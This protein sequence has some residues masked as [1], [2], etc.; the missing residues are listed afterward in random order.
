MLSE[1]IGDLIQRAVKD[2]QAKEVLPPFDMSQIEIDYP[3]DRKNGDYS[4][5][6]VLKIS[7]LVKIN[8]LEVSKTLA[9]KILAYPEA[10]D[11]FSKVT[12]MAPGFVNFFIKPEYLH[13]RVK[14]I[15]K[16]KEGFGK[17]DIGN[18]EKVNVEFISANPT[19]PL[20]LGNGRGGFCGDVLASVLESCGY[21]VTR[22]YY[23]NDRGEQIVKLGHS[24]LKDA[25]AVYKGEY[26]DKLNKRI[27]KGELPE[28]VGDEAAG[29]ILKEM[30]KPAV[31]RMG[32]NFDVWF[33]EKTLYDKGGVDG[34]IRVLEE[35]GHTYK[36]EGATWFKSQE[37]EDDKD[38]V[39]VRENGIRT[40]FAS[41]I[42]YLENKF[43]R[44]FKKLILFVGA[45]HYGYIARLKAGCQAMGFDKEAIDVILEQLVRLFKDGQEVRMSKRTGTYVT[46]DELLDEVG[47]DVARFFFLQRSANT[48]LN[49]D[50]NLAK[51]QSQKNPVFYIQYAH[52]RI[53][54]ILRKKKPGLFSS[55]NSKLLVEEAELDLIKDLIKFPEVILKTAKDYQ[56][57][58]LAQYSIDIADAFH[59]FYEKC[60]V[61]GEKPRLTQARLSL[62]LATKIV[63]KN[64]LN[65]MGISAPEK[66]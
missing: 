29:I 32:I 28:E 46:L 64:T 39:L 66:M 7:K 61:I 57:Q 2:L 44:G 48:H 62:T 3:T 25:D 43:Q 60:Q 9:D 34:V 56:V 38:R 19:G 49:F 31:K 14:E 47:L 50:L 20:T 55:T 41:D 63:L 51:E 5:N 22:E 40:Y 6:I 8:P 26:I 27:G 10:K 37:L 42:A 54:S 12:G 33:S 1:E 16:E 36:S 35:K 58:R 65:L 24:V 17:L 11:L 59:R 53:C 30:I 18:Q 45:D 52:A 4:S 23:V 15:I 13:E 21:D